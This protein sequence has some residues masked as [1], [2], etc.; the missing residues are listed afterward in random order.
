MEIFL[1]AEKQSNNGYGCVYFD[2]IKLKVP[3]H[4]YVYCL[5]NPI[6][7]IDAKGL[8]PDEG[9]GPSNNFGDVNHE[10]NGSSGND[11]GSDGE[12]GLVGVGISKEAETSF[13]IIG[14]TVTVTVAF[15]Q[16]L[17]NGEKGLFSFYFDEKGN[18]VNITDNHGRSVGGIQ[19][20]PVTLAVEFAKSNDIPLGNSVSLSFSWGGQMSAE[21]V[22]AV[23]S[24]TFDSK[25]TYQSVEISF[26]PSRDLVDA[27]GKATA[28]A[29]TTA[30]IVETY[31]PVLILAL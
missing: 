1:T 25:S 18:V 23:F 6:R 7:Y 9:G 22:N 13:Q 26:S 14:G 4:W 24:M 17:I 19:S 2:G 10:S 12:S 27:A 16:G 28:V 5:D 29:L 21:G 8:Y 20:A 30:V 31:G 11:Q 15:Y 3:G